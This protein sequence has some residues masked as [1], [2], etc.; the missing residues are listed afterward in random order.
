MPEDRVVD[1]HY[2]RTD[3]YREQLEE[4]AAKGLCPF[5]PGN[6][7]WHPNPIL[8]EA[9]G[10]F[11][12]PIRLNYENARLHL[13]LIG[14]QHK[15]HFLDLTLEDLEDIQ[16]LV[17]WAAFEYDLED[18]GGGFLMRFGATEYTG[19]SVVH[20]HAHLIV[21]EIDPETGRAKVVNFPIG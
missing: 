17:A 9:G 21:P 16:A 1:P 10:W 12:T 5:C 4:I 20:L 18:K 13:L 3:E 8:Y 14:L 7:D 15:E 19:A 11:I 6:F 2:A